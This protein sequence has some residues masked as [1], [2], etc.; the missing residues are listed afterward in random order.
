MVKRR[1]SLGFWLGVLLAA[2]FINLGIY[3]F[4]N[5]FYPSGLRRPQHQKNTPTE[6]S[7][8]VNEPEAVQPKTKYAS[9]QEFYDAQ[10]KVC[11]CS[12]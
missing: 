2:M 1:N 8:V 5:R 6:S 3:D 4:R 10:Y 7:A 11:L 9:M 12:N